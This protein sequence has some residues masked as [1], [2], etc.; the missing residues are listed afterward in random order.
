MNQSKKKATDLIN[1]EKVYLMCKKSIE[2]E[3]I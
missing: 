2:D 3:Y 1:I